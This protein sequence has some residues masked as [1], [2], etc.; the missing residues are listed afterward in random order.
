MAAVRDTLAYEICLRLLQ[1][2]Y[3]GFYRFRAW[4]TERVPSQGGALLAANHDDDDEIR[5]IAISSFSASEDAPEFAARLREV[6]R[7]DANPDIRQA[8]LVQL[9]DD[10][11]V[12]TILQDIVG[13]PRTPQTE[14][15][16][17]YAEGRL[18]PPAEPDPLVLELFERQQAGEEID[19]EGL[20]YEVV[21]ASFACGGAA[22]ALGPDTP[23]AFV[24][25]ADPGRTTTRCWSAPGVAADFFINERIAGSTWVTIEDYHEYRGELW[26]ELAG[27]AEVGCWVPRERLARTP[28]DP[29]LPQRDSSTLHEELDLFAG[30][31]DFAALW[32][33]AEYGTVEFFDPDREGG[34]EAVAVDLEPTAAAILGLLDSYRGIDDAIDRLV[35]TLLRQVPANLALDEELRSRL[36]A[37]A[38]RERPTARIS[39]RHPLPSDIR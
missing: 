25:P 2:L 30:G 36:D 10:A 6:A 14:S 37:V 5:L 31:G 23:R 29:L 20:G 7:S 33:V 38:S 19:W 4:N 11:E 17:R 9:G 35:R 22:R 24:L 28:A 3:V 12:A 15:L 1:L 32:R 8:A 16:V 13:E 21:V 18:A 39:P 34:V 26:V 27:T